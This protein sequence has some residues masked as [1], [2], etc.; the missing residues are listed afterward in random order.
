MLS[1]QAWRSTCGSQVERNYRYVN[2]IKWIKR[3]QKSFIVFEGES[4]TAAV[5][6]HDNMEI[7][8]LSIEMSG[9]PTLP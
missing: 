3:L 6:A 7:A 9:T 2:A 5:F 1:G 8:A 4:I